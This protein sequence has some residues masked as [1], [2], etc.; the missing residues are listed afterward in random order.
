VAVDASGSAYITGIT[1]E[2]PAGLP[3]AGPDTSHNGSLDAFVGKLNPA[4]NAFVYLGYIGSN[5]TEQ[6][7]DIALDGS[8]RAYIVG[9]TDAP[10]ASGANP[11]GFPVKEGPTKT[12]R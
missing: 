3:T 7:E 8:N 10:A 2:L 4:G 9:A 12:Y 11:Q 6:A 1:D 5:G